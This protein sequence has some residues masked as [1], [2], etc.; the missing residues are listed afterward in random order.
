MKLRV[1]QTVGGTRYA[2]SVFKYHLEQCRIAAPYPKHA[3]GVSGI[4]ICLAQERVL[5]G[6]LRVGDLRAALHPLEV[7]VPASR[8]AATQRPPARV[9]IPP[10]VWPTLAGL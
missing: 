3:Q 7:N 2:A 9:P 8:N 10:S 1:T 5:E 4:L 6:E